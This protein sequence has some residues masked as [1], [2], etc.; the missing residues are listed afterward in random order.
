MQQ[1][2]RRTVTTT[3][4]FSVQEQTLEYLVV[5]WFEWQSPG[6]V[7]RCGRAL[8]LPRWCTE[9]LNAIVAGCYTEYQSAGITMALPRIAEKWFL[10]GTAEQQGTEKKKK[11]KKIAKDAAL[12][13]RTGIDGAL[14]IVTL[15]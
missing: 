9:W 15:P 6:W 14:H 8:T 10:Q 4:S 3:T 2:K 7:L 12:R 1:V 5:T 13:G 11:G